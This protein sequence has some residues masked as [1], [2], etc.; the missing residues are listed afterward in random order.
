LRVLHVDDDA[1]NLRVVE[2]I[3]KAFGHVAVAASSG[4][5]A[6]EHL[7]HQA[8]DLVLLDIHMPG[9][10]GIDVLKQL[11]AAT[12]PERATP[13]IALT[14]DVFTLRP[15]EYLQLGFNDFVSKPILVSGLLAAITKVAA[16]PAA[17]AA[18]V[19]QTLRRSDDRSPQG[20]GGATRLRAQ[21]SSDPLSR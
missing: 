17:S 14:A 4:L 1:L 5:E 3:L 12:G 15:D 7:R 8:F 13:V 19:S 21:S 11:R 10:T 9:M 16:S 2:E 18:S 6:L 20:D